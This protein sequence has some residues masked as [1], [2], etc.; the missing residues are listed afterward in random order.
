MIFCL[1]NVIGYET[2]S[3]K[4]ELT[5][6]FKKDDLLTKSELTNCFFKRSK[7]ARNVVNAYHSY[8]AQNILI[9]EKAGNV[10]HKNV[11]PL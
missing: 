10:F 1:R 11:L 2:C 5:I 8:K 7:N 3:I 6:L 9:I 4:Q